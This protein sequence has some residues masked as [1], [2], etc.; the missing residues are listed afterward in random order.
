MDELVKATVKYAYQPFS[1]DINSD[2]ID[3]RTFFFARNFVQEARA[4]NQKLSLIT[5][6]I[7]N[8]DEQ[9]ELFKKKVS[10]PFNLNN[11]DVTVAANS[12]YGKKK[13]KKH[14]L[15]KFRSTVEFLL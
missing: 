4:N 14:F 8:I 6:W 12:V 10:M 13:L 1:A 15:L 7:Q 2:I 11:V 5:T 9:R 3:P